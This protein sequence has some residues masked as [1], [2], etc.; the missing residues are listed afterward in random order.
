VKHLIWLASYPKSGNTWL[1]ILLNSILQHGGK[2][3]G[4]NQINTASLRIMQRQ[5][6][7]EFLEFDSGEL[8]TSETIFFKRKYYLEYGLKATEDIF[9]KTHEANV[10]VDKSEHLIPDKVS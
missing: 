6:F 7:D 4:I 1:R 5:Q 9:I 2:P 8:T 3:V 10:T